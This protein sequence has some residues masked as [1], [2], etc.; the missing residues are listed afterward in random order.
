M[1]LCLPVVVRSGCAPGF[2]AVFLL[3][4]AGCGPGNMPSMVAVPAGEAVVGSR[5]VV[6]SPPRTIFHPA[7]SISRTEITVGQFERFLRE[8][9]R[10][11]FQSPQFE[12]AASG[13]RAVVDRRLPVAFVSAAD[14]A[15]YAAWL[16]DRF[17]QT[18]R[19]PT[20]DEWELAARGG[21]NGARYPWGWGEPEVS[22]AHWNGTHAVRVGRYE[23]NG[24]GLFDMAGNVAEWAVSPDDAG[25]LAWMLGGSWADRS[26]SML[27]VDARIRHAADYRGPD[28]GFRVVLD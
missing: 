14:A 7:F 8:G 20:P 13:I 12:G 22:K 25:G 11:G 1:D 3:L 17:G 2:L 6:G 28:V 27:R 5:D 16:G 9:G 23:A 18:G 21:V 10:P 4:A 15:A 24:W 26:T 19:L